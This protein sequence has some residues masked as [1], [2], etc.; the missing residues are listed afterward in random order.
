MY[1]RNCGVNFDGALEYC[2]NCRS[3]HG[4][5]RN[6]C[7]ACGQATLPHAT[8]CGR[9]GALLTLENGGKA[10]PGG[11]GFYQPKSRMAAGLLGIFLGGFGVHNFYL[12]NT[13][14]GV[15]Q[16]LVTI[17]TCGLG[18]LWG[19][20]EGILILAG[21]INTDADGNPLGQ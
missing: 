12:G 19:F 11:A 7:Q 10:A 18:S 20:I 8:V 3:F 5:G 9:C 14:I 13:T 1:C 21:S 17:F 4:F 15:I 6:Y 2:P 16:I